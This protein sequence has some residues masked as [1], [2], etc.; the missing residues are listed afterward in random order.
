MK[1]LYPMN[2]K[3]RKAFLPALI[4]SVVLLVSSAHALE[5]VPPVD[6][7]PDVPLEEIDPGMTAPEPDPVPEVPP[8]DAPAAEESTPPIPTETPP[9]ETQEPGP[10]LPME[11][12]QDM[13]EVVALLTSINTYLTY[14]F[15]F[16]ALYVLVTLGGLVYRFL[17]MFI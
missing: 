6:M 7:P 16:G 17:H 15:A 9:T 8:S 2:Q 3:M 4:L 14:L 12:S 10:E 1:C 13:T 11:P 5:D